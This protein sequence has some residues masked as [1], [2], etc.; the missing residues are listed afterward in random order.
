MKLLRVLGLLT[1]AVAILTACSTVPQLNRPNDLL[2]D[3][4]GIVRCV[5]L[6]DSRECEDTGLQ[7]I[8]TAWTKYDSSKSDT[9]DARALEYILMHPEF[10]HND[11]Y[12]WQYCNRS[13]APAESDYGTAWTNWQN[14]N[15]SQMDTIRSNYHRH[16]ASQR[17]AQQPAPATTAN[18]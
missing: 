3:H 17:A 15:Y 5:Y 11:S 14:A 9:D 7:P 10:Y 2:V 16:Q 4:S 8:T 1:A 6:K 12:Y 13:D 18:S